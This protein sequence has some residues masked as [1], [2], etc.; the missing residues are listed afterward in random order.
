M[1]CEPLLRSA[2]DRCPRSAPA[3]LVRLL[4]EIERRPSITYLRLE[5]DDDLVVWRRGS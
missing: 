2:R 5:K 3:P 4:Q 1:P